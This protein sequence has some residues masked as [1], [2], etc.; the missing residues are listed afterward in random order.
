M[1]RKDI[2]YYLEVLEAMD[3][4]IEDT[5]TIE[6]FQ[7]ALSSFLNA[8]TAEGKVHQ[9][10]AMMEALKMKYDKMIPL[11]VTPRRINFGWGH[12]LRFGIKGKKGWF[13][14]EKT[15]EAMGKEFEAIWGF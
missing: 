14:I 9:T 11:G 13:G 10:D 15:R 2:S 5:V 1:P 12:Q 3:V 8:K 6:K 7:S 4:P